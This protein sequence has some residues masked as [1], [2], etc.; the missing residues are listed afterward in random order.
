MTGMMIGTVT[1]IILDPV[2]ILVL[3]M[4]VGGAALATVIGNVASVVYYA[5]YLMRGKSI[6][7]CNPPAS[8]LGTVLPETLSPSVSLP[9]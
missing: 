6:L 7:S 3:K 8:L 2:M 4:G 9:L 5:I 1:N